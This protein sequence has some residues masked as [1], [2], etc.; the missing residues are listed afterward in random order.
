MIGVCVVCSQAEQQRAE[1]SAGE[2]VP[3][4]AMRSLLPTN[5]TCVI[6]LR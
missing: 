5:A 4:S 2:D 1:G 3:V 6:F